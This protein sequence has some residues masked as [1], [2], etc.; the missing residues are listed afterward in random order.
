MHT[1]RRVLCL[2]YALRDNTFNDSIVYKNPIL[3]IPLHE[4]FKLENL[5]AQVLSW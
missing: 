3:Q 2:R 1:Q 4:T 5:K